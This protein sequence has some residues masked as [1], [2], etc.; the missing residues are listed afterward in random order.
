M[1]RSAPLALLGI[2]VAGLLGGCSKD[3]VGGPE[4]DDLYPSLPAPVETFQPT[5]VIEP[6]RFLRLDDVDSLVGPGL[7]DG[8]RDPGAVPMCSWSDQDREV[9][10][11]V[12][13]AA[14]WAG[15]L[16]EA[17]RR[18]RTVP[19]PTDES[20]REGARLIDRFRAGGLTDEEA[21]SAFRVIA[22]VAAADDPV[23]VNELPASGGRPSG[24]VGSACVEGVYRVMTVVGPEV[25]ARRDAV[26]DTVYDLVSG[27]PRRS[28]A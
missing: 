12:L 3:G 9:T 6:C 22:A 5:T 10:I 7:E 19:F 23:T 4:R 16:S 14:D 13:R 25:T 24:V 26:A 17:E 21:C 11:S 27:P 1:R 2:L 18:S 15:L 28:G 8:T 20:R